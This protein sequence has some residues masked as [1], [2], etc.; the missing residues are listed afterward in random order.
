MLYKRQKEPSKFIEFFNLKNIFIGLVIAVIGGYIS[1]RAPNFSEL[2]FLTADIDA[3]DSI[4][5]DSDPLGNAGN[6]QTFSIDEIDYSAFLR[7]PV[8]EAPSIVKDFDDV[9]SDFII[10]MKKSAL[11][12]GRPE[13]FILYKVAAAGGQNVIEQLKEDNNSTLDREANIITNEKLPQFAADGKSVVF[14]RRYAESNIYA[15]YLMNLDESGKGTI[16]KRITTVKDCSFSLT[17]DG[18]HIVYS[19]PYLSRGDTAGIYKI[20]LDGKNDIELVPPTEGAVYLNPILLS[21]IPDGGDE[22]LNRVVFNHNTL[23]KYYDIGVGVVQQNGI[24]D[25]EVDTGNSFTV[26]PSTIGVSEPKF[27]VTRRNQLYVCLA[28]LLYCYEVFSN[29][30]GININGVA[31]CKDDVV[32][33]TEPVYP[34]FKLIRINL[35]NTAPEEIGLISGDLISVKPKFIE[36]VD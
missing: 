28:E 22:T 18:N 11:N 10:Y 12:S 13:P 27:M 5:P 6:D 24:Q 20:D 4:F 35:G 3:P 16:V 26:W 25:F 33:Y 14:C 21:F 29:A 19:K 34:N 23:V 8:P 30:N 1:L 36:H 7:A 32:Y 2:H 9:G 15:L 31:L 17:S